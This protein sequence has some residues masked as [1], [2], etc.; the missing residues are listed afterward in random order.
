MNKEIRTVRISSKRQITIPKVFSGFEK[1]QKALIV[2]IGNEIIIKPF[3]E[4]IS[5]TAL[6]SESALAESWNSTDDEEAFAYF[7]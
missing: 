5:E 4:K 3:P 7:Q 2:S 6:L 1:G